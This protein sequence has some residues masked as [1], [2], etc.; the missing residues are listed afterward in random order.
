MGIRAC[1][2]LAKKDDWETPNALFDALDSEFKFQI[3]VCAKPEN[4]KCEL[5]WSEANDSSCSLARR[6]GF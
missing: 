6:Y 3:D 5:F 1:L 2:G 4:A